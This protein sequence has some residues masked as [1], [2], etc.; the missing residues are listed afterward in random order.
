MVEGGD[1][2]LGVQGGGAAGAGGGDGLAVVVVDEVAGSKT[3]GR[4]VFVD[5][6]STRT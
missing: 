2:A 6:W 3:P 5:G 1:E 4:L